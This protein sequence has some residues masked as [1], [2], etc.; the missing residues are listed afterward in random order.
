MPEA[1]I[2]AGSG[3]APLLT[4]ERTSVPAAVKP[5][6][7]CCYRFEV[8]DT[9]TRRREEI[10][11]IEV[12]VDHYLTADERRRA[13]IKEQIAGI[14]VVTHGIGLSLGTAGLPDGHYLERVARSLEELNAR[15]YSEHIAFTRARGGVDFG[16]LLPLPR[17]PEVAEHFIRNINYARSFFDVPLHL[18][19][20]VYY[21]DY[22]D[23]TMED[24]EFFALI[25][26]ETGCKALLDVENLYA[27][28]LNNGADPKAFVN[29]L[30]ADGVGAVHIAGG[31]WIDGLFI[32]DHG[33]ATADA[34]LDIL[35][36]ALARHRPAVILIEQ[37]RNLG[38]GSGYLEEVK[39]VRNH[40]ASGKAKADHA[41]LG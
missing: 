39:R 27:N 34:V 4:E 11:V 40:V 12:M 17:R 14:P 22:N 9:I 32:D 7:G 26:R 28:L 31:E 36:Y 15:Y 35:D 2:P 13:R 41:I 18:E 5:L 6:V 37:D 19:N 23:A 1:S 3:S 29:A 25:A 20:I 24:G 30:P 8:A 16:E 21:F 10:D 33:H 38:D